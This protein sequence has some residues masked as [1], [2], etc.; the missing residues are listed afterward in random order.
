MLKTKDRENCKYSHRKKKI[1]KT[2]EKNA[3]QKTIVKIFKV[4]KGK[5]YH[6]PRILYILKK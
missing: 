3:N 4:M 1:R 2:A 6:Q 5:K